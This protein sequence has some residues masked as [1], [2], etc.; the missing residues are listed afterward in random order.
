MR[1]TDRPK[2]PPGFDENPEWTEADFASAT[3]GPHWSPYR[4]A[5][6]LREAARTMRREAERLD[7][8]ADALS[9]GAAR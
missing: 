5:M 9:G 6:V 3:L 4:A 2:P 7:A 1:A 8:E